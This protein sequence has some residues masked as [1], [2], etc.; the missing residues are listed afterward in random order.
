[1]AG[2]VE[3]ACIQTFILVHVGARIRF[4]LSKQADHYSEN[5]DSLHTGKV[6]ASPIPARGHSEPR[7][8]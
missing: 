4:F 2:G 3:S 7:E 6:Q 8:T 5:P 1:M